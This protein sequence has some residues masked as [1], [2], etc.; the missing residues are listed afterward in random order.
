VAYGQLIILSGNLC[1]PAPRFATYLSQT[2][3]L[4]LS[5]CRYSLDQPAHG[6]KKSRTRLVSKRHIN[7]LRGL[8]PVCAQS[9]DALSGVSISNPSSK[10]PDQL[11][12]RPSDYVRGF[13]DF[14]PRRLQQNN[15]WRTITLGFPHSN[16]TLASKFMVL[17]Y[18]KVI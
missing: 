16:N 1:S 15:E 7:R 5:S 8:S 14:E 2:Y 13:I 18:L 17:I 9:P 6:R 12:I 11:F 10:S 4:D 3:E